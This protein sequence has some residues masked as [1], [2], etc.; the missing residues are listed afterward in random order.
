M[1][2]MEGTQ[3]EE[4][5][6]WLKKQKRR[7]EVKEKQAVKGEDQEGQRNKEDRSW[8]SQQVEKYTNR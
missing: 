5:E 4:G 3:T 7:S 8:T 6:K 1:K 2:S